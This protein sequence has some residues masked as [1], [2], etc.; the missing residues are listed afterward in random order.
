MMEYRHIWG[1]K[2]N[3]NADLIFKNCYLCVHMCLLV[4]M[5]TMCIQMPEVDTGSP[6]LGF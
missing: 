4:F 1:S 5:C 2:N 3:T 6:A